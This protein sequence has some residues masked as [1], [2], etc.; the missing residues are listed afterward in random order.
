MTENF[1]LS[2]GMSTFSK[3]KLYTKNC[4]VKGGSGLLKKQEFVEYSFDNSK[5]LQNFK[6]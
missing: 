4:T 1:E 5:N 3:N 6:M 2:I